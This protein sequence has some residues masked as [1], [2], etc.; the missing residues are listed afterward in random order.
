MRIYFSLFFHEY[1]QITSYKNL[2][3]KNYI[4]AH[5]IQRMQTKFKRHQQVKLL[6]APLIEDVEPYV[7]PPIE[8]I[9]GMSG[10][11]NIILPNGQYH[12]EIIDDK[13]ETIAYVAMDEE[14]L[15]A[16]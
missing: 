1:S 13:G 5:T 8:I 4:L 6:R 12:V 7:E 2:F 9:G 15:E 3:A 14:G 11:V 10:K 16:E